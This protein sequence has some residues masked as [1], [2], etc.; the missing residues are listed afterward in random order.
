MADGII[1]LT[2]ANFG[3]ITSQKGVVLVDFWA[4]WCG[5]CKM[6]G[7]V[8]A[9]VAAALKDKAVIAKVN[10]DEN[11]ELAAQFQVTSI[12]TMF[13]FKDGEP[14]KQLMGLKSEADIT[15]AIEEAGR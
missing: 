2:S 12:P 9:K 11:Q 14:V 8:L 4:P 13:I 10:V 1:D 3:S 5:P 7:P 15:K 6:L